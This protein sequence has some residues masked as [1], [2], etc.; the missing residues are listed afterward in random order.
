[1]QTGVDCKELDGPLRFHVGIEPAVVATRNQASKKRAL[2][3]HAER[4]N[5]RFSQ[6]PPGVRRIRALRI[7]QLCVQ[8]TQRIGYVGEPLR[9][10]VVSLSRNDDPSIGPTTP[11]PGAASAAPER[12]G[13]GFSTSASAASN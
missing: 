3:G 4:A 10:A 6:H 13:A 11:S 5:L 8:R 7:S 1:M 9:G 12:V 2:L